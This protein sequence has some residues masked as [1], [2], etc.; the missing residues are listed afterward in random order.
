VDVE[1]VMQHPTVTVQPTIEPLTLAEVKLFCRVDYEDDD[2]LLQQLSKAARKRAEGWLYRGLITQTRAVR[3]NDSDF[4]S[5][6][7]IILPNPNV[8]SVSSI[9]YYDSAGTLQTASTSLYRLVNG[10]DAENEAFVELLVNQT[11]PTADAD[12]QLP[13]TV[14]YVCG[15]GAAATDVPEEIRLGLKIA[16]AT[17]Y[18]HREGMIVGTTANTMPYAT[19]GVLMAHR[20]KWTA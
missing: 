5:S 7:N 11:W 14:T 20:W 10:S 4:D 18:E 12:R 8:Q 3:L 6:G 2:S 15:Y 13:W 1:I 16:V 9:T 19:H 17:W